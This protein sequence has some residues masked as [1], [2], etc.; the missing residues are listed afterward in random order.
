[1]KWVNKMGNLHLVTGYAGQ[2]HIKAEDHASLN[3]SIV[4]SGQYVF[5]KGNKLSASA[6]TSNTIRV[7]DGDILMQ[8][9]HIRLSENSY[10]DLSIEN[11]AQGML[12]N[13]LIVARYTKNSGTGV[14]DCNL[15]V[16][17]GTAVASDVA[18]PE[19]TVGDIINDHALQNDMPLYR[20]PLNGLTIGELVPLFTLY[21]RDTGKHASEH[22][23]GG[24]DPITPASIGAATAN[25]AHKAADVGALGSDDPFLWRT[26]NVVP[27]V[28][29]D[30]YQTVAAGTTK[31]IALTVPIDLRKYQYQIYIEVFGLQEYGNT[32][33]KVNDAA[34]FYLVNQSGV[35][36]KD[37]FCGIGNT[38][39]ETD[40][41]RHLFWPHK[42]DCKI[43]TDAQNNFFYTQK[44]TAL[45][46]PLDEE[47]RST[48]ELAGAVYPAVAVQF[49]NVYPTE[50]YGILLH[51]RAYKAK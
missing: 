7:L 44:G 1:M 15:V 28:D 32:N 9:R 33:T 14:E 23:T 26:V 30:N 35:M 10:V 39:D 50:T 4:G 46:E 40:R 51:Y 6:I 19:Y 49:S 16:I 31:E 47:S 11:G 18:D 43:L 2:A 24:K 22:A 41:G 8:G 3:A 17:K 25:H 48:I 37:D 29:I 12:R 36:C 21:E 13:D 27:L 20:V 5:D 38:C 45:G 42:V 34:N